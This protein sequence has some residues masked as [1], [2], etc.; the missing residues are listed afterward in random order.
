MIRGYFR[1]DSPFVDATV[2]LPRW[3]RVTAPVSFLLD[4][5]SEL[6]VIQHEALNLPALDFAEAFR[7]AEQERNIGIGG[8]ISFGRTNA[9][10]TF[11]DSDDAT[12]LRVT[13][14]I[15]LS[16]AEAQL[17]SVLGMNFIIDFRLTVSR[18]ED[19][20]LLEPRF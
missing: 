17:P 3:G 6:T 18:R 20:V 13:I 10:L 12:P 19:L 1:G 2:N 8:T 4:T 15:P 7:A 16:R 9:F 5:G 11:P 14:R